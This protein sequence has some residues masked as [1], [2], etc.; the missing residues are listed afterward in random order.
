MPKRL[1]IVVYSVLLGLAL[2]MYY[3]SGQAPQPQQTQAPPPTIQ[4]DPL[5]PSASLQVR[6]ESLTRIF[7]SAPF[8]LRFDL[9]PLADGRARV[10][11]RSND[12]RTTLELIGPPEG[13]SSASLMAALPETDTLVRLRNVNAVSKLVEHALSDWT[14]GADW[15]GAN[16]DAA[17]TGRGV[18]TQAGR[19]TITMSRAPETE[20]LVVTITGQPL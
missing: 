20:T 12:G 1:R 17:F 18:S 19:K 6:R 5:R 3:V 2:Y 13:V 7:E 4:V 8:N 15:V 9:V 10:V 16:I 11:G 14:G